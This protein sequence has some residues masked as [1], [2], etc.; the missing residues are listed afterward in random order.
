VKNTEGVKNPEEE[1]VL[2]RMLPKPRE[3]I[4]EVLFLPL[5]HNEIPKIDLNP[6]VE[7]ETKMS[8]CMKQRCVV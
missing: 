8:L 1:H 5:F 7:V 2:A 6:L 4:L 3:I